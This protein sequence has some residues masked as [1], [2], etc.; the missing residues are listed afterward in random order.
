ML[1]IR[2]EVTLGSL[3]FLLSFLLPHYF[4]FSLILVYAL[5]SYLRLK[6]FPPFVSA[7]LL[8]FSPIHSLLVLLAY[9]LLFFERR[10]SISFLLSTLFALLT[11][12][13]LVLLLAF[14]LEKRGLIAS[15]ILFLIISFFFT[16]SLYGELG[17]FLLLAGVISAVIEEKAKI[18][19]KTS[20]IVY[21][22]S[23]AVYFKFPYLIPILISFSPLTSL[24]FSPFYPFMSIIALKHLE[25]KFKVVG[26]IP[27][28]ASF[29]Y[30]PL[31]LSPFSNLIKDNSKLVI[32]YYV[33]PFAISLYF[34][35]TGYYD[36]S[37]LF[38][39][40]SIFLLAIKY[41]NKYVINLSKRAVKRFIT[42]YPYV[43]SM[44]L[45]FLAFYLYF[46]DLFYLTVTLLTAIAISFP[47][48][49]IIDPYALS[50]AFLS[51]VN[52]FSGISSSLS[53]NSYPFLTIPLVAVLSFHFSPIG[54]IFYAIGVLMSLVRVK[55]QIK[56][57]FAIIFAGISYLAYA[58]YVFT[59]GEFS[60]VNIFSAIAIILGIISLFV[61]SEK[62]SL[63]EIV[64]YLLSALPIPFISLPFLY[65]HKR[66]GMI[67]LLIEIVLISILVKYV[68]YVE[69][70]SLHK[71]AFLYTGS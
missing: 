13:Y 31:A 63:Y 15:G 47:F 49:K 51:L 16:N 18:S 53:R 9:P 67:A 50:I 4:Y 33:I 25:K 30:P 61:K 71:I 56:S 58:I 8:L 41:L 43:I 29:F 70:V 21:L 6:Y 54:W 62:F 37:Q 48:K 26:I 7:V 24:L 3:L 36:L 11:E 22:S 52:P 55:S 64:S 65:L 60:A 10:Y 38:S 5:S 28:M 20:A 1:R 42:F 40:F 19:L 59:L 2:E 69:V 35:V 44:L 23:L 17:Y 66:I 32:L 39:I 57:G 68:S 14:A 27:S 12:N 46:Y 45:V 34:F